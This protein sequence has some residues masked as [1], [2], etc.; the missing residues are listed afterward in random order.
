MTKLQ[1]FKKPLDRI[2]QEGVLIG[3]LDDWSDENRAV[4][5]NSKNDY[6]QA[7]TVTLNYNRGARNY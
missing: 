3:Q 5:L 6:L 1:S 7:N 2:A 4:S